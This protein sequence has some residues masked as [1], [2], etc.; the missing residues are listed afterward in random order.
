VKS[1]I[2]NGMKMLMKKRKA[3]PT[4]KQARIKSGFSLDNNS[5]KA[6]INLFMFIP[7]L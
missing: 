2:K 6:S 7:L 3:T 1:T 5:L 4:R